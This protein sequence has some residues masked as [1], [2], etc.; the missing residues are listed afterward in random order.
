M[1]GTPK[2]AT[3]TFDNKKVDLPIHSPSVGPDVLDIR[4]TDDGLFVKSACGKDGTYDKVMY[5][6]GR[7]PN[8]DNLGLAEAGVKLGRWGQI[9][10]DDY[11]QSSVPSIYAV[12]DVTDRVNL[13]PVAIREGAAFVETVFGGNPTKPD[14]TL[15]PSAVF[16]QPEYG[17]VGL[18]EEDARDHEPIEVYCSSF[19]A[20]QTAFAD[21]DDR[22]MMKLIV[23]CETRKVL[24][25]HIVGEHAGELI[26]LAGVALK[27]SATK[28]DFDRTV[29]V[30]PTM[31]EE[32]VLMKT[33]VRVT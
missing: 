6:T 28:E 31:A 12:G 15:V 26:Q 17:S 7:R 1:A 24:G 19:R 16:T 10:V 21:R 5:A 33:P 27:M 22:V 14:H 20:M 29:A 2:T 9:E 18:S 8:S 25:C 30:H 32:L 13:T 23:S 3:L 4:Q 11:S